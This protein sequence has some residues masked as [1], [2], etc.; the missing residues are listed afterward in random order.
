VLAQVEIVADAEKAQAELTVAPRLIA[1]LDW[2]GRVLTGDA[3]FCQR[4]L[5]AQVG[6]A[7]GDYLVIVKE[8]Q[9][10]LSRDIATSSLLAPMLPCAPPACRPGTCV[11]RR[12]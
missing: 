8:N 4:D 6:D 2:H 1:H 3:L 11:Q 9:P 5:C 12:R 10:Q 7:G